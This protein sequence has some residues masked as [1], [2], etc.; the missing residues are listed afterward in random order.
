LSQETTPEPESFYAVVAPGFRGHYKDTFFN[1]NGV[2][3]APVSQSTLDAL[4]I[5][6]PKLKVN[7]TVLKPE[8]V[9]K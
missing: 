3:T 1:D 8:T 9:K 2:A 5:D 7:A 4:K 6:Y